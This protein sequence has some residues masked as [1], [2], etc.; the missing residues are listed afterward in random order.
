MAWY[1]KDKP[2]PFDHQP[3]P[4]LQFLDGDM[5][6][7]FLGTAWVKGQKYP[8]VHYPPNLDIDLWEGSRTPILHI[9]GEMDLPHTGTRDEVFVIASRIA[10]ACGYLV[11]KRGDDTIDA[12]GHDTDEH[13]HIIFDNEAKMIIDIRQISETHQPRPDR[14]VP[15]LDNCQPAVLGLLARYGL[16]GPLATPNESIAVN[17]GE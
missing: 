2:T 8:I 10:E 3:I 1:P 5:L 14:L 16:A 15:L 13:Y 4:G 7:A 6:A 12:W 9:F 11:K 17:L